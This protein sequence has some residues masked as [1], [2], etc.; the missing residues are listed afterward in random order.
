MYNPMTT[1]YVRNILPN[2]PPLRV[3][4]LDAVNDFAYQVTWPLESRLGEYA[5]E[6]Y[7][8]AKLVEAVSISIRKL[9]VD[10]GGKVSFDRLNLIKVI[11]DLGFNPDMISVVEDIIEMEA[12]E[13]ISSS[14]SVQNGI[15]ICHIGNGHHARQYVSAFSV[16]A[17]A[18]DFLTVPRP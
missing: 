8:Q 1:E 4:F 16:E 9:T 3:A 6:G 17:V 15:E 11:A 10:D 7:S 5:R 2:L 13:L 14:S 18:R 12:K